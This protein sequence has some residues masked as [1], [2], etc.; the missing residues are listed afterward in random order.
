MCPA[1]RDLDADSTE[2]T[3]RRLT[4]IIR[5]GPGTVEIDLSGLGHLSPAG[6]AASS[7]RSKP[8]RA[9]GTR[10]TLTHPNSQVQ[11]ALRKIALERAL[12]RHNDQLR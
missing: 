5:T 4:R 3:A 9:H 6:C 12:E 11:A 10:L 7:P 2:A 1:A 8:A